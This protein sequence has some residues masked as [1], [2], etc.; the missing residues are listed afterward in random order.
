MSLHFYKI[1]SLGEHKWVFLI[2]VQRLL[3][4]KD[5]RHPD[6]EA[7]GDTT[8]RPA[9]TAARGQISSQLFPRSSLRS[10]SGAD[11]PGG[12]GEGCRVTTALI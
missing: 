5:S 2:F 7:D 6:T 11:S 8:I 10:F 1:F 9:T 4:P 12:W 3:P